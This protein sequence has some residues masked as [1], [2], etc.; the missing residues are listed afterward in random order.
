MLFK[1]VYPVSHAAPLAHQAALRKICAVTKPPE[2]N[3]NVELRQLIEPRLMD[4]FLLCS[5][6]KENFV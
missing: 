1:P 3:N 2:L 6:H 5:G 4:S